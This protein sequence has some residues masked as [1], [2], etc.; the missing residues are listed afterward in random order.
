MTVFQNVKNN[1]VTTRNALNCRQTDA[2][3]LHNSVVTEPAKL[4]SS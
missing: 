3:L 1:M 4:D 2:L